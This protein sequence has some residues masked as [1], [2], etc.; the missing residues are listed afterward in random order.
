MTRFDLKQ[1]LNHFAVAVGAIT[2]M[3]CLTAGAQTTTAPVKPVPAKKGPSGFR[4]DGDPSPGGEDNDGDSSACGEDSDDD[5]QHEPDSPSGGHSG[6]SGLVP[7]C[8][9][10]S[11]RALDGYI[12]KPRLNRHVL[13]SGFECHVVSPRFERPV[14]SSGLDC[15]DRG[16]RTDIH[17]WCGQFGRYRGCPRRF[18]RSGCGT[19]CGK[20]SVAGRLDP[21]GIWLFP[22]WHP[23][24][25]RF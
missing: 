22:Q 11:E 1:P 25:L 16:E 20:L 6:N 8:S 14:L 19:R 5:H 24:V 4:E 9:Y 7:N 21:N 2:L 17:Q 13:G 15:R 18:P 3:A 23:S 12:F 10:A